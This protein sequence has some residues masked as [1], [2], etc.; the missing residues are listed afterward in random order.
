MF[1]RLGRC[2]KTYKP[3]CKFIIVAAEIPDFKD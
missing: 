3:I 1:A 2:P